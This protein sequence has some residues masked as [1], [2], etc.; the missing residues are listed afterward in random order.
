MV[1]R[2]AQSS[3]V[4]MF[5]SKK[6]SEKMISS[7]VIALFSVGILIFGMQDTNAQQK[8]SENDVLLQKIAQKNDQNL[9]SKKLRQEMEAYR[10]KYASK[11]PKSNECD[12][13]AGAEPNEEKIIDELNNF[14]IEV[15]K[16]EMQTLKTN[17]I[18][19]NST[20]KQKVEK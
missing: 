2:N 16:K 11:T 20:K 12:T 15:S 18:K 14:S 6:F 19:E 5:V 1:E 7:K 13:P 8:K 10:E 4:V 3:E 9:L 17:L